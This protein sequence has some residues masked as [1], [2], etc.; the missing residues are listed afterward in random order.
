[1][2]ILTIINQ[3]GGV[4]KSTTAHA[5]GSGLIRKEKKVLFIDLDPQGNLS[6]T[7]KAD[8]AADGLMEALLKQSRIENAIQKIDGNNII[9]SSAALVGADTTLVMIGKEYR[10]REALAPIAKNYD[11][12]IIDTPPALGI[13][14]VNAL[15]ASDSVIIP[16][17][18]DIY[19]LQGIA[20]LYDTIHIIKQYCN[21]NLNVLGIV[22]T[23]YTPRAILSRDVAKMLDET[24]ENFKT[25]LFKTAIR[26]CISLKEAQACQ[27]DIF[28]YA[29]KSNASA[30][31]ANLLDEILREV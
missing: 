16:A 14:T 7:L 25:K 15:T 1:M 22:L 18:A 21:S 8:T 31:Y 9:P 23:R 28:S 24:A 26:E 29:P 5:I 20:Q 27:Q 2:K 19:S 11:Y 3:K 12:I 17:Q 30:D 13:L 4:G 6:Y 10:L